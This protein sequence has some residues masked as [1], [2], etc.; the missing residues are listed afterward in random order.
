MGV[1]GAWWEGL[2]QVGGAMPRWEGLCHGGRGYATVGGAR[3]YG[4]P[5][6]ED[7]RQIF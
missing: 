5:K 1:A 2:C 4:S 7:C 6:L 3:A